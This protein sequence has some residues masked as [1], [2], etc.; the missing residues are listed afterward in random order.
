MHT[1]SFP[2]MATEAEAIHQ[3]ADTSQAMNMYTKFCG[4]V[5]IAQENAHESVLK[6]LV[7]FQKNINVQRAY[8]EIF[9]EGS[10]LDWDRTFLLKSDR[11]YSDSTTWVVLMRYL[12]ISLTDSHHKILLREYPLF[13]HLDQCLQKSGLKV[14]PKSFAIIYF[15]IN[16]TRLQSLHVFEQFF[17]LTEN[18][19][20]HK[21]ALIFF[22]QQA[23]QQFD[24]DEQTTALVHLVKNHCKVCQ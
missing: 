1:P 12:D 15:L 19:G 21:E 22:S 13:S 11:A 18:K 10:Y 7:L 24:R 3:T 4:D 20:V 8:L 17:S 14:T 5:S 6:M 23:N 2:D 9:G 16:V